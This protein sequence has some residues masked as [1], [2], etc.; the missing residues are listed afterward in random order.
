MSI[1]H[2]IDFGGVTTTRG[3]DLRCKNGVWYREFI[4]DFIRLAQGTNLIVIFMA[5]NTMF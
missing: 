4:G 2:S 5:K 1:G 3:M